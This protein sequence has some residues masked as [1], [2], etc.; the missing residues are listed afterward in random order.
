MIK[1]RKMRWTGLVA[2]R[3]EKRFA[4]RFVVGKPEE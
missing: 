4:Y 2:Y 1:S 3:G